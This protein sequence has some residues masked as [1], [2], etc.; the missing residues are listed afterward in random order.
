MEEL[1]QAFA[2]K[3][4]REITENHDQDIAGRQKQTYMDT[5]TDCKADALSQLHQCA[6]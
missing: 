1:C 2:W 4:R 6:R 3:D 5:Y